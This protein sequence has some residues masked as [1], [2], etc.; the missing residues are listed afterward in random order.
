[1]QVAKGFKLTIGVNCQAVLTQK[2]VKQT[3]VK[4][5]L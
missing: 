1:M 5:G 3:N 4:Q 2:G